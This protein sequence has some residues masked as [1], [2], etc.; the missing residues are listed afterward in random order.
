[1]SLITPTK[2]T[3]TNLVHIGFHK[4]ETPEFDAALKK[5]ISEISSDV[6]HLIN[7]VNVKNDFQE[8]AERRQNLIFF[9]K[10]AFLM[11][12]YHLMSSPMKSFI[13]FEQ[14]LKQ[15]RIPQ[16]IVDF[17]E[18]KYP[19][20]ISKIRGEKI[21]V[22]GNVQTWPSKEE[23]EADNVYTEFMD[24]RFKE[25]I[26]ALMNEFKWVNLF[27]LPIIWKNWVPEFHQNN[28][29]RYDS[30]RKFA[31]EMLWENRVKDTFLNDGQP[32]DFRTEIQMRREIETTW[33]SE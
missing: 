20:E 14:I 15:Q 6:N 33:I 11:S 29:K 26:L 8:E 3:I 24:T 21:K 17:I 31:V 1:M 23:V 10:L 16:E 25:S 13:S 7:F 27:N 28:P 22:F 5:Y 30:L 19:T 12:G 4:E 32:Q 9:E 18:S 2:T